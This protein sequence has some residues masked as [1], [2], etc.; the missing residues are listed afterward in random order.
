MN[1]AEILGW[2]SEQLEEIRFSGFSF[3]REGKYE[4]ARL[5]F[6]TLLILDTQSTFDRQT[7]GAIY[8]QLG[9][10]EKAVY[11]LEKALS[12]DSS[13]EPTLLN[14]AKAQLML[15]KKQEAMDILQILKKS[16]HVE[17]ANDATALIMAHS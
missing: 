2:E 10:N 13:H 3:L 11:Q 15:G 1:W 5:Y 16:T 6:E 14:K 9:D 4:K 17:L 7:L 12:L 8:L